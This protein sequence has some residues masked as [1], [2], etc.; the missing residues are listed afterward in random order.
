M[1]RRPLRLRSVTSRPSRLA[2]RP[3]NATIDRHLVVATILD[4]NGLVLQQNAGLVK[5]M[6]NSLYH[7]WV[8]DL[9]VMTQLAA[10]DRGGDTAG[11]SQIAQGGAAVGQV[12]RDGQ[13]A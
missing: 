3:H 4:V 10:D 11:V 7:A 12:E 5:R 9:A 2:K 6:E 8:T 13:G 1:C